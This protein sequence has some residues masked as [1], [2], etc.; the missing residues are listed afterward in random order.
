MKRVFVPDLYVESYRNINIKQ[1]VQLG[2]RGIIFDL[3]N[4]LIRWGSYSVPEELI[5]KINSLKD[6][7]FRISIVSNNS[8]S[9]IID[10]AR[11]L[12]VPLVQSAK[13]PSRRPF[14]RA[15]KLMGTD[16][17]ETAMVGDQIFTDIVGG[18]RAGLMTILVVPVSHKE[19]FGTRLVRVFER[20]V[21]R[22]MKKKGFIEDMSIQ[23]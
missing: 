21:L 15:M 17:E 4:T 20:M 1:L 10:F 9:H 8:G 7:G 14:R 3:D 11:T 2:I 19:F 23:E 12:K 18:N 16:P 5:E 13:K 22:H 6:L